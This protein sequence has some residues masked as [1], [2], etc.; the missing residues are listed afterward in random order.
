MSDEFDKLDAELRKTKSK[1]KLS[2]KT[3]K[4]AMDD[5]ISAFADNLLPRKQG[6]R[7]NRSQR[8]LMIVG[9]CVAALLV[10]L[11][12][13]KNV[14]EV[15]HD[16]KAV[17]DRPAP[18]QETHGGKLAEP[19]MVPLPDTIGGLTVEQSD[20]SFETVTETLVTQEAST[21]FVVIPAVFETVTERV[22]V[23]P[24][25]T[26]FVVEPA[27]YEWVDGDIEGSAI[28]YTVTPAVFDY[29]KDIINVQD[30]AKELVAIPATFETIIETIIIR[31]AYIAEDGSRVTAITKQIPRQ[32]VSEQARIVERVIPSVRKRETRRVI[33]TP[34]SAVERLVPY[35]KQKGKTRVVV[36]AASVTENRVP[37]VTKKR[38]RRVVKK[39]TSF[40]ENIKPAVSQTFERQVLIGPKIYLRDEAGHIVREFENRDAFEIYQSTLGR[41]GQ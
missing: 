3:R 18:S 16:E 41:P 40:I 33:K 24:E 11:I 6:K 23:V 38:T 19:E 32:V 12:T 30:G 25:T 26:R 39:A 22:V 36:K 37:P 7:V 5:D 20:P 27:V 31:P 10:G 15:R 28:E 21:E 34:A 29:E 17:Q 4:T 14:H 13:L 1:P 2:K 9:A 35:E 8:P